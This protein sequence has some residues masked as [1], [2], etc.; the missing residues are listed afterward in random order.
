MSWKS[1][2]LNAH[3]DPVFIVNWYITYNTSHVN[4]YTLDVI[5]SAQLV[6]TYNISHVNWYIMDAMISAQLVITYNTSPV[7]CYTLDV[8]QHNLSSHKIHQT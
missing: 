3:I 7:N 6:I 4:W 2:A 8:Y 5:I 1:K